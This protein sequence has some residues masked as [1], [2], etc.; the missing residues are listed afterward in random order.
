MMESVMQRARTKTLTI[1]NQAFSGRSDQTI[2]EVARENGIDIPTLCA[3]DGLSDIGACRLCLVEIDGQRGLRPACTTRIKDEMVVHTDTERLRKHRRKILSFLFAERNHVCS[4]C[5]SN[6]HCELQ[7]M[8]VKVGL[9]HVEVPYLYPKMNVDASHRRFVNDPNRCILCT[10]CVRVCD[11]IEGA[12]ILDI[13]ARGMD[14]R[15]V[16]EMGQPWGQS[17]NC[18]GCGKCVQVCPTGAL[19]EKGLSVAEQH[20]R[21]GFLPYLTA[22]K[23]GR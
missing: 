17:E 21:R 12:H 22:M 2:L 5:V 7:K 11:E 15:I 3:I 6:A 4:V 18:T 23:R 13:F 14:S 19:S 20:K 16:A 1:N 8:A 9:T 10:R